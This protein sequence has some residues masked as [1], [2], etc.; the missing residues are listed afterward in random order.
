M[1]EKNYYKITKKIKGRFFF[2][3]KKTNQNAQ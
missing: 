1:Q 2:N 3:C